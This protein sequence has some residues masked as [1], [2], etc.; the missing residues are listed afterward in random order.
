[1]AARRAAQRAKAQAEATE[2][3]AATMRQF[4]EPFRSIIFA[5]DHFTALGVER[6]ASAA[7]V[8]KVVVEHSPP[9]RPCQP[10]G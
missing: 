8:H 1:M 9:T 3:N 2:I 6:T 10:H 4:D 5:P 7:E